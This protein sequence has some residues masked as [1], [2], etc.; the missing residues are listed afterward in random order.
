MKATCTIELDLAW[1]DPDRL[2]NPPDDQWLRRQ[3]GEAVALAVQDALARQ[4]LVLH[5]LATENVVKLLSYE[6]PDAWLRLREVPTRPLPQAEHHYCI[7][8]VVPDADPAKPPR[9]LIPR[10]P[11]EVICEFPVDGLYNTVEEALA[12]AV[13]LDFED[14]AANWVIALHSVIPEKWLHPHEPQTGQD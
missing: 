14:D 5:T 2:D 1:C 3:I 7:R 13:D 10:S 8:N 9:L 11:P 6:K 12:D 4:P